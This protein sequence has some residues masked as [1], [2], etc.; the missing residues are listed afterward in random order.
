MITLSDSIEVEAA[1]EAVFEWMVQRMSDKESYQAWHPEHLDIRWMKGNPLKVGSIGCAEEYLHGVL[2]TLK[3][4][5]VEIIPDRK[6]VYRALFPQSILA[7]RNTFVIKPEGVGRCIFTAKI[8]LRLPGWLFKR[9]ARK[10]RGKIEAI[11]R[12]MKEEGE[13][14]KKALEK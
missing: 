1:P 2:H 7:A 12:H 9:I 8:S 11:E 14:L 6:I 5:I 13:N 3:F 4:R 10:H